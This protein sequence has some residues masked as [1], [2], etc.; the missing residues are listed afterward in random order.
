M[1]LMEDTT[2]DTT[3]YLLRRMLNIV[4]QVVGRH[5]GDKGGADGRRQT[6]CPTAGFFDGH[7]GRHGPA[8]DGATD[9]TPT[10]GEFG[11]D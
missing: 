5:V 9:R 1:P 11:K 2:R 4:R 10:R 3:T 7:T 6:S 8:T